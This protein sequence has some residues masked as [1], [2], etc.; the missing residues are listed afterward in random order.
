MYNLNSS[1]LYFIYLF[2][3]LTSAVE[4]LLLYTL[5]SRFLFFKISV[6]LYSLFGEIPFSYFSYLKVFKLTD[7]KSLSSKSKSE[8]HQ[9]RFLWTAISCWV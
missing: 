8:L 9:R 7:L 3:L 1:I 4:F 2:I 5:I 6:L